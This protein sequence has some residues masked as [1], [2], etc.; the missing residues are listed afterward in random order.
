MIAIIDHII[1]KFINPHEVRHV[2]ELHVDPADMDPADAESYKKKKL[3][4]M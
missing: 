4:S 3:L 2:E 1:P